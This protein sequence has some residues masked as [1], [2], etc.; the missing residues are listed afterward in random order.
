MGSSFARRASC[1]STRPVI[2]SEFGNAQ[3]GLQFPAST[4]LRHRLAI[5]IARAA[6]DEARTTDRIWASLTHIAGRP[7]TSRRHKQF[8]AEELAYFFSV[9][10]GFLRQCLPHVDETFLEQLADT[11]CMHA[12][13]DPAVPDP[14]IYASER[15]TPRYL[16]YRHA[17]MTRRIEL[18]RVHP[19]TTIGSLADLSVEQLIQA[20][21]IPRSMEAHVAD[22]LRAR[23]EWAGAEL[24]GHL[25]PAHAF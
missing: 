25:K 15:S 7:L 23:L 21:V 17:V 18:W 10:E 16:A 8:V 19:Y 20:A 1:K 6:L 24:I 12:V 14:H 2:I 9:V 3:I 22:V 4:D 11:T 13:P 5:R